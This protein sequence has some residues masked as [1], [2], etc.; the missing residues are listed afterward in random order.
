M[1]D[2]SFITDSLC[3]GSWGESFRLPLPVIR[4]AFAAGR[5]FWRFQAL[6]VPASGAFSL[7]GAL[8]G[9]TAV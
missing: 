8:T 1:S 5:S 3:W 7:L 6:D 9:F 2:I 4:L